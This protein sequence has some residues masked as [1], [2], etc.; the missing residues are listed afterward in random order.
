MRDALRALSGGDAE[1]AIRIAVE[2][3]TAAVCFAGVTP[4]DVV[5]REKHVAGVWKKLVH[6]RRS[7]HPYP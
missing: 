3:A 5:G 2:D 7:P 1:T 4:L 6:T